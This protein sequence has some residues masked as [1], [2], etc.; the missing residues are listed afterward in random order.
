MM[1]QEGNET[2]ETQWSHCCFPFAEKWQWSPAVGKVG[3]H[4]FIAE[5]SRNKITKAVV[6]PF[7]LFNKFIQ[8]YL[9]ID[10]NR[11]RS[12]CC[13]VVGCCCIQRFSNHMQWQHYW[14]GVNGSRRSRTLCFL[15]RLIVP[16]RRWRVRLIILWIVSCEHEHTGATK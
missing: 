12:H 14:W 3:N 13:Q 6:L 8:K 15:F 4:N 11:L 1:S 2:Q 16:L 5:P 10:N 9:V 7:K